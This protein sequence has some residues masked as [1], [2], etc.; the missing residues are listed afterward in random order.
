MHV[1]RPP[2]TAHTS[3]NWARLFA[4]L[5]GLCAAL[6][7]QLPLW[8]A[9]SHSAR[10]VVHSWLVLQCA[11]CVRCLTQLAAV[12]SLPSAATVSSST[13][14][15]MGGVAF[16]EDDFLRIYGCLLLTRLLMT[17]ERSRADTPQDA[18]K[19]QTAQA[20]GQS[21]MNSRGCLTRCCACLVCCVAVSFVLSLS[22]L[23]LAGVCAVGECVV[24][25]LRSPNVAMVHPVVRRLC[26]AMAAD[27]Q[28]PTV[29]TV[30]AAAPSKDTATFTLLRGVTTDFCY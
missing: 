18:Q 4:S 14:A 9:A 10:S 27:T 15:P 1:S 3:A 7:V 6:S 16:S 5:C 24:S 30:A 26:E 23:L 22:W 29:A 19:A 21:P 13:S 28:Q 8:L 25:L 2:C 17:T 20:A 12:L 11:L